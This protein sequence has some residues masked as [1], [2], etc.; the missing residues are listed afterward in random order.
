MKKITFLLIFALLLIA[1][2]NFM[3][4]Q[5][6]I[7]QDYE[8]TVLKHTKPLPLPATEEKVDY[9]LSYINAPP[10]GAFGRSDFS[11]D[12]YY[13]SGCI[14]FTSSDMS[15]Y[16]GKQLYKVHVAIPPDSYIPGCFGYIVWLKNS[17][18][19]DILY[20]QDFDPILGDW[21]E[22][23][24]TT[25]HT[26]TEGSFVI[27]YTII[28]QGS[29]PEI[30]P[31]WCSAYAFDP[32]QPGG[33]NYKMSNGANS[34]G[35]G[36]NFDQPTFQTGNLAIIGYAKSTDTHDHDLAAID[37]I[38]HAWP[39]ILGNPYTYSVSVL[40][41]GEVTQ[42]NYTV[43][44]I[45]NANTLLGSQTVSAPIAPQETATINFTYNAPEIGGLTVRGKVILS[46]DQVPENDISDPVTFRTYPMIPMAYCDYSTPTPVT[47]GPATYSAAI[48]YPA[49]NMGPYAGN[50]LTA[51]E[52][53]LCESALLLWNCSVW[54]RSSLTGANLYSQ[55]FTPVNGWNTIEFET[56]FE[57]QNQTTYIGYTITT[58]N[59]GPVGYT[60]NEP[61]AANRGHITNGTTWYSLAGLGISGNIAIIGTV[62]FSP[63]P[64]PC[65]P[66]SFLNVSYTSDCKAQLTWNI[67]DDLSY[68]IYRNDT[69]IA[70]NYESVSY[71]D[72]NF[73][74]T[75]PH[76]WA[77]KTIC[78]TGETTPAT[79]SQPACY[80][81]PPPQCKP[82]TNFTVSFETDCSAAKLQWLEPEDNDTPLYHIYRDN[83]LIKENHETTSYTDVNIEEGKSY[84]WKIIVNCEVLLSDPITATKTCV[85][86]KEKAKT[87]FSIVPNPASDNI[88]VSSGINFH[89]IEI[90]NF[91]GQTILSQPNIGNTVKIDISNLNKGI[92]FVRI[93]T[94]SSVNVQKFV[95]E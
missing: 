35:L 93:L 51:I 86:I 74:I 31:F 47:F 17:L 48:E 24:L 38:S 43:Q 37:V 19:G 18:S 52:L 7:Q 88:T 10:A 4:A 65:D 36:A 33:V 90:I 1:F 28:I 9:L 39:K 25:P 16:V 22:I 59:F 23:I 76:T 34:Y 6:L 69:L 45:D 44:L 85:G 87:A 26:I 82:A 32:Y 63:P 94:D 14:D 8:A 60:S 53:G 77:V 78:P 55:S 15:N 30:L 62:E 72:E 75:L 42:N 41:E 40:N 50:L 21:S 81:P 66:P 27:G 71:L 2:S 80:D 57:L 68:N 49:A 58:A 12:I 89:T 13:M 83:L 29:S 84:T 56:P 79:N 11:P 64:P 67:Q 61:N 54:V 5:N 95:K 46:G 92:Y 73:E 70:G 3:N 20:Q 91:L